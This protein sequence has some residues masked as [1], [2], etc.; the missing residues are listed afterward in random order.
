MSVKS[1]ST[2]AKI[3]RPFAATVLKRAKAIASRYQVIVWFED[4]E[5]FGRGLELPGVMADGK[6]AAACF[7]ATQEAMQFAVATL[8]EA[9][10]TPPP[11][12]SEGQRTEQVNIRVSA[13]EKL[14]LESA[15]KQRGYRGLA[16]FFR[17]A[18]LAITNAPLTPAPNE[19]E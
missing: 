2:S 7:A 18:A 15:A 17:A 4:G 16:D 12:A 3:D 14:Q 19:E 8:L 6:T 13:E 5:Y 9:G 1:K 11:S 10:Q